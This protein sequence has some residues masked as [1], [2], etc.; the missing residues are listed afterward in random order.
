MKKLHRHISV[1][2]VR[3]SA[4]LIGNHKSHLDF[5]V[6]TQKGFTHYDVIIDNGL[7][8]EMVDTLKRGISFDRLPPENDWVSFS[9]REP[10]K[11]GEYVVRYNNRSLC[12][13]PTLESLLGAYRTY[14]AIEWRLL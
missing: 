2:P 3:I 11:E 6:Q 14:G 4:N 9:D 13:F 10:T 7:L 12:T 5:M 1:R 8:L